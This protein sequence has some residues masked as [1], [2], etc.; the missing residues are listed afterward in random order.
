MKR[1]A[2]AGHPAWSGIGLQVFSDY[3]L[4][5][6]HKATLEVLEKNG[7]WVECKDAMKIFEQ[8]GADVN[9]DTHIVKFPM[10]MVEEAIRT[11][12]SK[13]ILAG[14]NPKND[15]V[16]EN[17]RV[18]F[19]PFGTGIMFIDPYTD[20]YRESTKAD[21]YK[22]ALVVDALD[23]L[24]AGFDTIVPRDKDPRTAC[25]HSYEAHVTGT[26]KN[27]TVTA[28]D[29]FTSEL[30]I[31]MAAAVVGGKENLKQRPIIMGGGCPISPLSLSKGMTETVIEFAKANLPNLILSMALSGGT[32]AVTIAGTLVGINAEILSGIILAQLV[33]K[34]APVVY[35]TSTTNMDMRTTNATVGSP[36][37]AMISASVAKLAQFYNLPSFAA[38]G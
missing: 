36:E 27:L 9:W 20:E 31:E 16:L 28:E 30:L 15:L 7:V 5:S 8:G 23:G 29:K 19:C 18:N 38:G 4:E 2:S 33:N 6:I 14:R 26:S 17:G 12:P 37:L 25:L 24:D 1:N 11:A 3:E 21:I 22:V 34:G 35:G 32:S 10:Y 13:V